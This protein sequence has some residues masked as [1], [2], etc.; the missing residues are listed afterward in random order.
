MQ[1]SAQPQICQ[2]AIYCGAEAKEPITDVPSSIVLAKMKSC[3]KH[4]WKKKQTALLLCSYGIGSRLL[5]LTQFPQ[6]RNGIHS[7]S[8]VCMAT[9]TQ[10]SF[11]RALSVWNTCPQTTILDGYMHAYNLFKTT[12]LIIGKQEFEL[13]NSGILTCPVSHHYMLTVLCCRV[14]DWHKLDNQ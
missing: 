7:H 13:W 2:M 3:L 8:W 14:S 4:I 10:S 11:N 6:L 9:Y 12:E 1:Q 5:S